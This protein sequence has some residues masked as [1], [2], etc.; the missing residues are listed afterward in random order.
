MQTH[1]KYRVFKSNLMPLYSNLVVHADDVSSV[2]VQ[3]TSLQA[4]LNS[5]RVQQMCHQIRDLL[6]LLVQAQALPGKSGQACRHCLL[7]VR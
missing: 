1:V 7:T 2:V 6:S 4:K 3:S 5:Q